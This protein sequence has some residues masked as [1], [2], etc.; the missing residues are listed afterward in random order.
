MLSP[1]GKVLCT[2]SEPQSEESAWRPAAVCSNF[3]WGSTVQMI[4]LGGE[5]QE[6]IPASLAQ[7]VRCS[8]FG[9]IEPSVN[10][11][12]RVLTFT[13]P[14]FDVAHQLVS[15]VHHLK[16]VWVTNLHFDFWSFF[17]KVLQMHLITWQN[18]TSSSRCSVRRPQKRP[19]LLTNV[20]NPLKA[21]DI[22]RSESLDRSLLLPGRNTTW[23]TV[24]GD[25]ETPPR[26]WVL[27]IIWTHFETNGQI[28][29]TWKLGWSFWWGLV[30]V[31]GG[32]RVFG[33]IGRCLLKCSWKSFLF[34]TQ[35][36]W[37]NQVNVRTPCRMFFVRPEVVQEWPRKVWAI[38]SPHKGGVFQGP[39]FPSIWD[40]KAVRLTGLI[41]SVSDRTLEIKLETSHHFNDSFIKNNLRFSFAIS[42]KDTNNSR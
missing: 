36:L 33:L 8:C 24:P 17:R 27:I 3:Y 18:T 32:M 1:T 37:M 20:F 42:L 25:K 31:R 9:L 30:Q 16:R 14:G 34:S 13:D 23:D 2:W 21:S 26:V 35:S 4:R 28:V 6:W 15:R 5:S 10:L 19:Y 22:Q 39:P 38:I 12:L 40:Q 11:H 41:L 7:T 29:A